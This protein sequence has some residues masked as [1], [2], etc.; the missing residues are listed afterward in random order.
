MCHSKSN[1]VAVPRKIVWCIHIGRRLRMLFAMSKAYPPRL[2]IPS[3]STLWLALLFCL[4]ARWI[5]AI[6]WDLFS[7]NIPKE[8]QPS[9]LQLERRRRCRRS[10]CSLKQLKHHE[11]R[12]LLT[13]RLRKA[14]F[15]RAGPSARGSRLGSLITV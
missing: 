3:Q 10:K 5:P 2:W 11:W 7:R 14:S 1:Y 6:L 8:R 4:P 13:S 12:V 9:L 15:Q